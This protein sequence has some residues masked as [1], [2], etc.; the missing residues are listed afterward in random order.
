MSTTLMSKIRNLVEHILAQRGKLA[1]GPSTLMVRMTPGYLVP[2]TA[3]FRA[4]NWQCWPVSTAADQ[5]E[6]PS[7]P[8]GRFQFTVTSRAYSP[9]SL[10][11]SWRLSHNHVCRRSVLYIFF[12][13]KRWLH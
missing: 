8:A 7:H 4:S 13:T 3:I 9:T 11:L 1:T 5:G 6:K 12:S 10:H 2:T